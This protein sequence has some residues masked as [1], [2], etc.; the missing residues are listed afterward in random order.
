MPPLF[1]ARPCAYDAQVRIC[2]SAHAYLT[3]NLHTYDTKRIIYDKTG[4]QRSV[5]CIILTIQQVCGL[6]NACA[7]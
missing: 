6:C 7:T 2:D 3:L 4:K 5:F 1:R